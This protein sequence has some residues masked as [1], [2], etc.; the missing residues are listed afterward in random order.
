MDTCNITEVTKVQAVGVQYHL[1]WTWRETGRRIPLD[2]GLHSECRL[3]E[4]QIGWELSEVR[5]VTPAQ[6]DES[7]ACQHVDRVYWVVCRHI[8][9]LAYGFVSI[10]T[11]DPLIEHQDDLRMLSSMNPI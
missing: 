9:T 4:P 11:I 3:P 10:R 8:D 7:T 6:Q 5:W 1:F 2:P